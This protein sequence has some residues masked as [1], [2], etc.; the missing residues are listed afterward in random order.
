MFFTAAPTLIMSRLVDVKC[1][2]ED[3]ME[4]ETPLNKT[5]T[6]K[7]LTCLWYTT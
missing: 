1:T 3:K 7:A 5:S 6:Q 2:K 4:D